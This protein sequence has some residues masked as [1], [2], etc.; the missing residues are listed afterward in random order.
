[1][2]PELFV[3]VKL[4]EQAGPALLQ[5]W[6]GSK[7]DVSLHW[8][9]GGCIPWPGSSMGCRGDLTGSGFFSS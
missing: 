3:T 8:V 2:E 4:Q 9:Q 1:M 5:A 7:E 6:W